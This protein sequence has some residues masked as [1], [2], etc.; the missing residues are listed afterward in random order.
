[1]IHAPDFVFC[2]CFCLFVVV[3]VVVFFGGFVCLL[4]SIKT[5]KQ[6]KTILLQMI[7]ASGAA[8][9][10]ATAPGACF[11]A[12]I[13]LKRTIRPMVKCKMH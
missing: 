11:R 5:A 8:G 9:F 3:V 7:R 1:M 10:R 4:L 13:S 6:N 12:T 2:F